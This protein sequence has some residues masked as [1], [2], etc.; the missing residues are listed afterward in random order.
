M[1]TSVGH[2]ACGDPRPITRVE[3]LGSGQSLVGGNLAARDEDA[4]VEQ[5]RGR[6][7]VAGREHRF[8]FFPGSGLRVEQL[9][10]GFGLGPVPPTTSARPSRSSSVAV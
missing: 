10:P 9:H 5:P 3:D 4:T 1:Q 8:R 2:L 6:A 7:L